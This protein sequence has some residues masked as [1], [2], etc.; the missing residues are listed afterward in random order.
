VKADRATAVDSPYLLVVGVDLPE[1]DLDE[2]DVAAFNDSYSQI[3]VPDVVEAN[4]GFMRGTR[5]QLIEPDP[6]GDLGPRWLA[7]YELAD[8]TAVDGYL[9][10]PTQPG[11]GL[12]AYRDWA[13]YGRS[14]RWRILWR[15][16]E[17]FRGAIG[18]W[19]RPYLF[20]IGMDVPNGTDAAGLAAF[21]EFYS[22]IHVPEVVRA[23]G[24]VQGLRFQRL[25]SILHPE[26]GCPQFMA[27]YDGDEEAIRRQAE[28]VPPGAIQMEGPEAWNSRQTQWRLVYRRVSSY[29]RAATV[30]AAAV[31]AAGIRAGRIRA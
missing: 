3:H 22:R 14:V 6:R 29:S 18:P 24:Y 15:R 31:E 30:E 8:R 1:D 5:Y 10:R 27:T 19:G 26:P 23:L 20:L 17:D 7:V 21:N 25:H 9:Q 2:V 4:P 11:P 16:H 28:G 13:E 12:A